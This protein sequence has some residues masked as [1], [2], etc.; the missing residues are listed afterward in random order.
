MPL[1]DFLGQRIFQPLKMQTVADTNEA[2]LGSADPMRYQRF[3]LARPR[4]APK[5]G[6]GWMFAAGELAMTAADLAAWDISVMD[7][8]VMEPASYREMETEVQLANGAGTGYGLG[9]AVDLVNGRRLISH[10]GEVSGF[11]A[12]NAI[13]PDDHLAIVV[14]TNLDA[15]SAPH[16]L[17]TAI[18]R[19]LFTPTGSNAPLL[20]A[21]QILEGLQHGKLERSLFTANANA[22][23]TREALKDLA[24]SL[25]PL[26]KPVDFSEVTEALRGGMTFHKYNAQFA[27]KKLTITTYVMPDGKLE[28][29]IV[30]AE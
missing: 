13:Y 2:A 10:A 15:T 11:T 5:E 23:F 8:T 4:P 3:G 29:Y 16:D 7:Q 17:A 14:L 22:Y 21:K 1:I 28:Q 27:K 9:V 30:A 20:Q 18:A 25:A 6:K 12:L 24:G 19:I 26:G